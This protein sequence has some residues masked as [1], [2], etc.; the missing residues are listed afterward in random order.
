M[1]TAAEFRKAAPLTE[2]DMFNTV[3]FNISGKY[4]LEAIA[5]K[6]SMRTR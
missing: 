4:R 1:T 2:D 5:K 3:E 6:L